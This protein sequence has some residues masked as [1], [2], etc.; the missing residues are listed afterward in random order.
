MNRENI[1]ILFKF[2]V[3]KNLNWYLWSRVGTICESSFTYLI[4]FSWIMN[5]NWFVLFHFK[6]RIINQFFFFCKNSQISSI[7]LQNRMNLHVLL[8]FKKLWFANWFI[9]ESGKLRIDLFF[10]LIVPLF[11]YSALRKARSWELK[12]MSYSISI[13]KINTDSQKFHLK[14]WKLKFHFQG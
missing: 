1:N 8:H 13:E 2:T 6:S 10:L 7:E 14:S 12:V 5:R 11:C 3:F 4:W 9:Q